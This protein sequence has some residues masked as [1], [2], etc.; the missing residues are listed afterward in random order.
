MKEPNKPTKKRKRKKRPTLPALKRSEVSPAD[1]LLLALQVNPS[2]VETLM[3]D[4][5][6]KEGFDTKEKQDDALRHRALLLK[7]LV[8]A[9]LAER[10]ENQQK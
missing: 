2:G 1:L 3:R 8:N 10:A 6:A 4:N 5:L 7:A 9:V